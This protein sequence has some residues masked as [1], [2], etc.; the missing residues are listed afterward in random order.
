MRWALYGPRQTVDALIAITDFLNPMENSYMILASG[1]RPCI[2]TH[3]A[4]YS[5]G[6]SS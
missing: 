3:K 5:P 1:N 4:G 6:G 2:S